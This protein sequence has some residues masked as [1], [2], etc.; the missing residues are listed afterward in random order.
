MNEHWV[1]NCFWKKW[2]SKLNNSF[3]SINYQ[4]IQHEQ[5]TFEIVNMIIYP[6]VRYVR[7]I[8]EQCKYKKEMKED[9][10]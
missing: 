9:M 6:H 8:F 10:I 3:I 5:S 2:H 1:T 7:I 4:C